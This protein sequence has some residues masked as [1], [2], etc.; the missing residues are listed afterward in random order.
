MVGCLV[1]SK[2]CLQTGTR[3]NTRWPKIAGNYTS[4]PGGR[5]KERS[6]RGWKEDF[7]AATGT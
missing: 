2:R 6:R 3:G 1:G 7:E 4:K 5:A